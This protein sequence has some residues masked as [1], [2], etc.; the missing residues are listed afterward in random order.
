[1]Q[2]VI[3]VLQKTNNN[4]K[5]L[6]IFLQSYTGGMLYRYETQYWKYTILQTLLHCNRWWFWLQITYASVSVSIKTEMKIDKETHT[7]ILHNT[8][9]D[10]LYYLLPFL[11]SD[12]CS[13]LF[14]IFTA[15]LSALRKRH[16]LTEQ[17]QR[18]FIPHL[19]G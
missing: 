10:R 3:S 12:I 19:S 8:T 2:K 17:N 5:G 15:L 11:I 6:L 4:Y 1:M 9:K 18:E 7:W 14:I 16:F 13:L